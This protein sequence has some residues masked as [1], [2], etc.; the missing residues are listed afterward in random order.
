[1]VETEEVQ[2]PSRG[3]GSR[4]AGGTY[5]CTG[6]SNAGVPVSEFLIDPVFPVQFAPFRAPILMPDPQDPEV[7]HAFIWVG[8]EFYKSPWDFYEEVRRLGASRRIPQGFDVMKLTP[9]RSRLVFVHPRAYTTRTD[10]VEDGCPKRLKHPEGEACFGAHRQY[11]RALGSDIS[12]GNLVTVSDAV[13]YLAGTQ[14]EAEKSEFSAGMFLQLPLTHIEYQATSKDDEVPEN[15]AF[16]SDN[17]HRVVM[18]KD[19]TLYVE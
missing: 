17:G 3:C 19:P 4:K 1:M 16:A 18:C 5:L 11:Q 15:L 8:E 13:Q 14:I 9:G 2:T 6:L 10:E 12:E 7:M